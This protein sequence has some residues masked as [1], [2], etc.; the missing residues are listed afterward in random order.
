[1]CNQS[2]ISRPGA[3]F[4]QA[5]CPHSGNDPPEDVPRKGRRGYGLRLGFWEESAFPGKGQDQPGDRRNLGLSA[6]PSFA[7]DQAD[8]DD[9]LI[10][11]GP[12]AG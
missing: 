8:M 6:W 3:E 12:L 9:G 2:T 4:I 1:M 10:V 7:R 5:I 11:S